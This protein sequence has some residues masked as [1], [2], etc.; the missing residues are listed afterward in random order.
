MSPTRI[1]MIAPLLSAVLFSSAMAQDKADSPKADGTKAQTAKQPAASTKT[2]DARSNFDRVYGEWKDMMARLA[3]L[4][5][6]YQTAGDAERP[7]IEKEYSQETARGMK[8][9]QQLKDATEASF[10]ANPKDKEVSDLM[11]VMARSAFLQDDYEEVNR[12]AQSLLK[13]KVNEPLVSWFAA[14]AA[15]GL[16]DFNNVVPLVQKALAGAPNDPLV[17]SNG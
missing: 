8:L 9:A 3:D 10:V 1:S 14:N 13:Y 5:G 4:N 15:L 11:S 6:K 2:E 16:H 17:G 12:F 7:Q